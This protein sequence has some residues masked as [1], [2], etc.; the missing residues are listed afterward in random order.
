MYL[1]H[2][3]LARIERILG[4][5][6]THVML[7]D[8]NGQVILPK[9]NRRDLQLPE[10]L[11]R[12]PTRPLVYGGFT[13]I[14][15]SDK[16]PLYLCMAGDSQ[17]VQNCIVVCAE[18]INMVIASD[19]AHLGRE[20]AVRMILRGEAEG[21]ELEGIATEYNIP[22]ERVRCVIYFHFQDIEAKDA[23]DILNNI[24]SDE[25]DVFVEVGRHSV[26]L[27]KALGE[28]EEFDELEQMGQATLNTFISETNSPVYI[29]IG[30]PKQHIADLHEGFVEAKT[31]IEVGRLYRDEQQV[32]V[33]RKLLIE[34]F[35][36]DVPEDMAKK[37][38]SL[39]FNRSTAR[40]FNEEMIQTI[41]KFFENSLNLSETARQLYIHR[42]TLVYRLD[43]VQRNIGLDLRDFDDAVTFKLMMLLGRNI[44]GRKSW[45]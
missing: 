26:A 14:G 34:R 7:L 33:F 19:A 20:Q 15:T 5:L 45:N 32:F 6:K 8:T 44:H 37:Y 41:K 31:A 12:D 11:T 30:E 25:Q 16:Q 35:L 13:L 24:T 29:G 39:L 9:D 43:K 1:D 42:N 28:D 22:A 40:L 36:R 23:M 10:M 4:Q 3:S 17:D 2:H 18:L 38:N 21:T 27:V